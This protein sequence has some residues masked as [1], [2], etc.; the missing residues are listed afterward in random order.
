[1]DWLSGNIMQFWASFLWPFARISSMLMTMTAIGAAFVPARVRLLLAVAVTLASLPSIPAMPQGIELFSLH[2][3]L[4]TAQ[5]ILIGVAIGMI[6]QFLTQIFVMLGQ[7]VSMQSS[8]GFASMVDPASGQ[9]TPLLGQIYM[10]LT[11]LVFLLL[12]GHLIM[13]EMLVRSFTTLPVGE[14]GI[15]AGGYHLLSQWFGILFLGSVSMS[16]SAIISLLT[17]NIAMGIMNRAAPQLNVYS[18]G[19]GLILLCGLFSLWYLLSAFPRHYDI[20]WRV[21]LDDMCT[22]LHMTCGDGL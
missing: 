12:D 16:L 22:L 1:M 4:I 14:T 10:M 2:S 7:I 8:L 6:S 11:L 15:T 3:V 19:F 5:Q 21:A 20:Y 17:V 9:N 13:I 18:L